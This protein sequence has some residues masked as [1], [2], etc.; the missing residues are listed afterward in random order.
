MRR[1]F[2]KR[3]SDAADSGATG[4]GTSPTNKYNANKPV[5]HGRTWDSDAEL[6]RYEELLV[7]QSIGLVGHIEI[8]PKFDIIVKGHF[9]YSYKADFA[10]PA[11][12]GARVVEDV[13]NPVTA[14]E[15]DF[16]RTRKLLKAIY[17]IDITVIGGERKNK[18]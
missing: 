15:R 4:G 3:K 14:R 13:K 2:G 18:K 17:N 5:A 9:I 1:R 8:Q 7:L 11:A 10:Y 16:V 6:R 12:D